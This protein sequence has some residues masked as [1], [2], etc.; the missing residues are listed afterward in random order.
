LLQ[1]HLRRHETRIFENAERQREPTPP[2]QG[3]RDELLRKTNPTSPALTT[4]TD[5]TQVSIETIRPGI[6]S[7]TSAAQTEIYR[8]NPSQPSLDLDSFWSDN[9][10]NYHVPDYMTDGV[11]LDPDGVQ[12]RDSPSREQALSDAEYQILITEYPDFQGTDTCNQASLLKFIKRGMDYLEASFPCI[13]RS[14]FTVSAVPTL[15]LALCSLGMA[16]SAISETE[17][18]GQMLYTYL[19]K[20][21]TIHVMESHHM[22]S[23]I[24]Q[25]MLLIEHMGY[26][27]S[28]RHDHQ[29]AEIIHAMLVAYCRQ[30][31]LLVQNITEFGTIQ[32]DLE[33]KW[34]TWVKHETSV[35]LA[36]CLFVSDIG[37]SIHCMEPSLLS[38]GMLNLPLPSPE[39][40]WQAKTA[41]EWANLVILNQ[42]QTPKTLQTLIKVVFP[43]Y[44][45]QLT[46]DISFYSI[47]S[48]PDMFTIHILIHAIA[49]AVLD[50][51]HRSTHCGSSYAITL[52]K[53]EDFK[54]ALERWHHYFSQI[55][56]AKQKTKMGTSALI[57]FHLTWILLH[58]DLSSIQLAAGS[59]LAVGSSDLR[60]TQDTSSSLLVP[61]RVSNSSFLHALEIVDI[62]L[63]NPTEGSIP[64]SL[65]KAHDINPLYRNYTA[66]LGV[67]VAWAY[68]LSRSLRHLS[69]V[70]VTQ[71]PSAPCFSNQLGNDGSFLV[72]PLEVNRAR[73][74]EILPP[75]WKSESGQTEVNM[76]DLKT[77]KDDVYKLMEI[78]RGRLAS[79]SWILAQ[80]SF[81]IL[82]GLLHNADLV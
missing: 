80:E 71:M 17:R 9:L 11:L 21:L 65:D 2:H 57:T 36:Y 24:L 49:S 34:K 48:G 29:K 72:P 53:M 59:A 70:T 82:D 47:P 44:N 8:A 32:E 1:V 33:D 30:S 10:G 19:S 4:S 12:A 73:N 60:E 64:V 25:A 76:Q 31:N 74:E 51:K 66:F 22:E 56:T 69:A 37:H 15:S 5:P 39:S 68:T 14:T 27:T 77:I 13:H 75:V 54:L 3:H 61:R 67:M 45:A 28:T 40:L 78:V 35:R 26:H 20:R 7:L 50:H 55:N 43:E 23:S 16:L 63:S 38:T 81:Q 18:I 42:V 62:C 58:D 41:N 52:L 46:D 79:S 6:D